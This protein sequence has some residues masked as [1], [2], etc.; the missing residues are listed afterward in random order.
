MHKMSVNLGSGELLEVEYTDE[1]LQQ[2][3]ARFSLPSDIE[4][5]PAL[6]KL[7]I[8]QELRSALGRIG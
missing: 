6:I 1:L 5:E 3:R 7:F 8:E 4:I 2:V